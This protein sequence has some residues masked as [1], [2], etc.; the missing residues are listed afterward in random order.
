MLVT[1]DIF[2][3]GSVH[4]NDL[5]L[6]LPDHMAFGTNLK[7]QRV[8]LPAHRSMDA[9]GTQGFNSACET[10]TLTDHHGVFRKSWL[11]HFIPFIA[12]SF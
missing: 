9:R 3:K 8:D 1:H 5:R 6:D 7:F 10:H 4:I 2:R 11:S 12:K